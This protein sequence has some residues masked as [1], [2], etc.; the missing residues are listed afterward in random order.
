[1]IEK[2]PTGVNP[3]LE[4]GN[5]VKRRKMSTTEFLDVSLSVGTNAKARGRKMSGGEA[6][7]GAG[8]DLVKRKRGKGN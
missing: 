5:G 1:M 7:V 6:G 3:D 8:V 4:G 2:H